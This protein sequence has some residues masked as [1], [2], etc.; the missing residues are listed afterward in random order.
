MIKNDLNKPE[1]LLVNTEPVASN[2]M[3]SRALFF[4]R[5]LYDKVSFLSADLSLNKPIDLWY[6]KTFYGKKNLNSDTVFLS[7]SYLK[8]IPLETPEPL[9]AVNFVVDAFIGM[10]EEM[11]TLKVR[12]V[13]V[14]EGP[15][16]DMMPFSA[17]T[18]VHQLYHSFILFIYERFKLYVSV[19]NINKKILDFNSFVR[20][21]ARFVDMETPRFPITRSKFI[22]LKDTTP[23][24]SGLV[25]EI[26]D[27]EYSEDAPKMEKF[28]RDPNF[29]IYKETA[30]R[31]GFLIDKHAPWRLVADIS[32]PALQRYMRNYG[33]D[34][35]NLFKE[36]YYK[37][38]FYDLQTLRTY[39]IAFYNS[40]VDVNR[41]VSKPHFI[42]S[43]RGVEVQTK[44]FHRQREDQESIEQKYGE[45]YW[46]RMYTFIRAREENVPWTQKIFERTVRN[47]FYYHAKRGE[48]VAIDFIERTCKS[49]NPSLTKQRDYS[50]INTVSLI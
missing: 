2:N 18:S 33:I 47:A 23:S 46:L 15:I 5:K 27:G 10:K 37:A 1:P 17:W 29:A 12:D 40:F 44:K 14:P 34:K 9:Y 45:Q 22:L 25:I 36:Y 30:M 16:Y 8:Q 32:S 43:S 4:Q 11:N 28:I 13:L 48:R 26:F 41:V 50:F 21:F 38:N 24:I 31:Y 3:T 39:I 42:V 49:E 19:Q 20:E 6:E 7:E 35:S